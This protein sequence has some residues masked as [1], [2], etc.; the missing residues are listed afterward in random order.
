MTEQEL[1]L[2]A[3]KVVNDTKFWI[4]LV[5]AIGA[6]VGSLLTLFGN[7][8]LE[9]CRGRKK[10]QSDDARQKIL[11]NMLEDPEYQWRDISTLA[12]VVGCNE[13][14]TKDHLIAIAARGSEN[15]NGKWGLISKHPLS[16]IRD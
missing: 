6:I 16:N 15:D 12:S 8:A 5:G 9:W 10:R 3:A 4:G 14:Q 13:E 1:S 2:I 11:K 7:I